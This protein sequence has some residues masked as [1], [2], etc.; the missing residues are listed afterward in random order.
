MKLIAILFVF[1]TACGSSVTKNT[2]V[3]EEN[4]NEN[5][6]QVG[7]IP[8]MV[9]YQDS[10]SSF[11]NIGFKVFEDSKDFEDALSMVNKTRQPGLM[12]PEIDFSKFRVA[13]L[14]MGS[15]NSGGYAINVQRVEKT[16]N[17]IIVYYKNRFPQPGEM[18][19]MALTSPWTM[20]RF[21]NH[22]LPVVFAP[23]NN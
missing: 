3:V 7:D 21:E 17:N 6:D 5:M 8:F 12:A 4:T 16:E 19:T 15:R 14:Q 13:L 23:I 2:S 1:L 9:L 20:V 11:E 10:N 18:V 22:N